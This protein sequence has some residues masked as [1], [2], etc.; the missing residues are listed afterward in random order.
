MQTKKIGTYEAPLFPDEYRQWKTVYMNGLTEIEGWSEVLGETL[1][2]YGKGE[3]ENITF[4]GYNLT[5]YFAITK[6]KNIGAL[7]SG[8][9]ETSTEEL[10]ERKVVPLKITYAP[11]KITVDSPEEGVNTSLAVHDVFKGNFT[12][13]NRLVYVGKGTTEIGMHYP[14]LVQGVLMSAFGILAAAVFSIFVKPREKQ[15]G[16]FRS[17]QEE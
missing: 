6:D 17:K 3:N 10:P 9:V 7:L 13:K 5:Y 2:F 8:I 4:V 16:R 1:P 12:E 15:G 11:K 14:Y